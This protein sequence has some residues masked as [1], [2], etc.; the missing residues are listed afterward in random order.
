MA[1]PLATFACGNDA[2]LIQDTN[3]YSLSPSNAAS[4]LIA[5]INDGRNIN[6]L[7]FHPDEGYLYG[8]AQ[9]GTGPANMIRIGSD[10]NFNLGLT[11]PGASTYQMGDIDTDDQYWVAASGAQWYK[12]DLAPGS[13]TYGQIVASNVASPP[14]TVADWAYVPGG[15]D[16]LY[17]LGLNSASQ[18]VLV[19]FRR[20]TGVWSNVLANFGSVAGDNFWGGVFAGS[21]G[22]LYGS[23]NTSGQVWKFAIDGSTNKQRVGVGPSNNDNDAARCNK[24]TS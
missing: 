17:S 22:F 12:I 13:S 8:V 7:G 14:V 1:T 20:S 18:T 5:N 11:I 4:S 15:G 6:A 3:L 23:E 2:Y 19:R 21:D 16:Y 9:T 24:A 10:G